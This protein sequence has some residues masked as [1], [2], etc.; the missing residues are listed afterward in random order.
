MRNEQNN[1]VN[2]SRWN[3]E[4]NKRL[5]LISS[6]RHRHQ[7]AIT[8]WIDNMG[9]NWDI[10]CCWHVPEAMRTA[11]NGYSAEWLSRQMGAYLN[12][13][14]KHAYRHLPRS[15]RPVLP[16]FITI[17]WS[18]GTGWHAHGLLSTP[19]HLT[20]EQMMA[21]T[22]EIW[23][24]HV[25]RFAS[26]KFAKRL[27][28]TEEREGRYAAYISKQA[29]ELKDYNSNGSRGFIDLTNTARG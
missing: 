28:W 4:L 14:R 21:M 2:D 11:Q 5:L 25:G 6:E 17:E 23:M 15:Q 16:R 13:M 1:I 19:S 8:E 9:E 27:V 20:A 10:A 26:G 29:M 24:R 7:A 3:R 18:E 12:S 22:Q